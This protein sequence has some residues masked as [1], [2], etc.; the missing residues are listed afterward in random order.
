MT[1]LHQ[2][3]AMDKDMDPI[4]ILGK[5]VMT[6]IMEAGDM[7]VMK[8]EAG[9]GGEVVTVEIEGIMEETDPATVEMEAIEMGDMGQYR[10]SIENS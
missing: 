4:I 10:H 1:I 8:E 6:A 3:A 9:A 2:V 5:A 7:V